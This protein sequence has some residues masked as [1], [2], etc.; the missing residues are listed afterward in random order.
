MAEVTIDRESPITSEEDFKNVLTSIR[1]AGENQAVRIQRAL[2]YGF[3]QF[4]AHGNTSPLS[5]ALTACVGVKSLATNTLK[6]YLAAA[7][8]NPVR[9]SKNKGAWVVRKSKKV[10]YSRPDARWDQFDNVAQVQLIDVVKVLKS[11]HTRIDKGRDQDAKRHIDPSQDELAKVAL[12]KVATLVAELE[13]MG[14]KVPA[15]NVA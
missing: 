2:E 10:E 3:D 6:G 13:S 9:D 4:E 8:F 11:T 12:D 1:R 7:G 14:I 15:T 5:W